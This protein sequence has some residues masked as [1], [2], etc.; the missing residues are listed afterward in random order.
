[1]YFIYWKTNE[2]GLS[3]I[4]SQP[5]KF[6]QSP[7]SILIVSIGTDQDSTWNRTTQTQYPQLTGPKDSQKH[8]NNYSRTIFRLAV[9]D[10]S[11]Y[12]KQEKGRKEKRMTLPSPSFK[13]FFQKRVRI[14][15]TS[16]MT[17]TYGEGSV[18][19]AFT[20]PSRG[21]VFAVWKH[22]SPFLLWYCHSTAYGEGCGEKGAFT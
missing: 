14:L 1:M 16:S 4:L 22:P 7:I 2:N 10:F 5:I 8:Y 17:A 9:N 19:L 3:T 21:C 11:L 18:L 6:I 12:G 15:H 20:V 13:E